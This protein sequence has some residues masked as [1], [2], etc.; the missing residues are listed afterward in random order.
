MSKFKIISTNASFSS[1][2]LLKLALTGMLGAIAFPHSPGFSQI[3]PDAT[4]NSLV[5]PSEN[6]YLLTGGT[7]AGSNLFHSFEQ[8]SVPPGKTAFFN[9]LPNIENIITR[10]TGNSISSIDGLIQA[11][12]NA[13]LFLLNPNGI[14]FGKNAQLN[15]VGSFLATTGNSIAFAD[16]TE[17]SATQPQQPILTVTAPIGVQFGTAAGPIENRSNGTG[18]EVSKG[19]TLS[20]IGGEIDLNG[21]RIIAPGGEVELGSVRGNGRVGLGENFNLEFPENL[22]RGNIVLRNGAGINVRTDGGGDIRVYSHDLSLSEASTLRAGI[23]IG[24]G[25]PESV[26]GDIDIDLTGALILKDAFTFISNAVLWDAFGKS[27]NVNIQAHSITASDGAQIF[28]GTFGN[29]DAGDVNI[30]VQGDILLERVGTNFSSSGIFNIVDY[31]GVGNAG[32]ITINAESLR[33]TNGGMVYASTLGTGNAGDI[34]IIVRDSIALDGVGFD[35]FPAGIYSRVEINDTVGNGGNIRVVAPTLEI[36]NG[37]VITASTDGQ[38]DAGNISLHIR[39]VITLDGVGELDPTDFRQSSGVFSSVKLFGVGAGG[40]IDIFTNTLNI[41][42]GALIIT[43]TFNEGQA[44]KIFIQADNINVIGVGLN[45]ESSGIL[46]P[47]ELEAKSPA[48]EIIINTQNLYIAEGGLLSSL[49]RNA[50]PGGSITVNAR[51]LELVKGGQ[52]ITSTLGEG[53]AGDITLN[54]AEKTTLTG[55]YPNFENRPRPREQDPQSSKDPA[56]GFFARTTAESSGTGGN[57][58][59]NTSELRVL[60]GAKITVSA[61]GM[62]NAGNLEVSAPF[63]LIDNAILTAET[64]TGEFGNILILSEDMRLRHDSKITTNAQGTATGGNI[65]MNTDTLVALENSDITANS[66]NSFGGR[67]FVNAQGIFGTAFREQLTPL[68]DITASSER[69]VEFSG[70]VEIQLPDFD[71]TQGLAVFPEEFVNVPELIDNGCATA[72][73]SGS[74]FIISGRGGKPPSPSETLGSYS[75]WVDPYPL[76]SENSWENSQK[77][78]INTT[79]LIEAQGMVTHPNG[80]ILLTATP[81]T[82]TPNSNSLAFLRCHNN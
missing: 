59:I 17:F 15:L 29:G 18:L 6:T 12:G 21:G 35:F 25:T 33:I 34:D 24:L 55:L 42:N 1:K 9:N 3:I 27:G 38:G 37:A 44:G 36:T 43:N 52:I 10:I 31:F 8:F 64:L 28:S 16:G 40:N 81:S 61:E 39:D 69:G 32:K 51:T 53:K 2:A 76:N 70:T 45:G 7:Q 79:E 82:V 54:I 48:G 41:T 50:S 65:F 72:D 30:N 71:P 77:P 74:T 13:N 73:L 47:T 67:V 80:K 56:S 57:V 78:Q 46:T 11:N 19:Q 14:I 26:G 66:A 23:N 75:G 62:G 60:E 68:S 58:R 4:V 22:D 63:L 20:L 5:T 49:T